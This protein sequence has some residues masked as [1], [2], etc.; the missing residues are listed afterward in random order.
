M[1]VIYDILSNACI[2]PPIAYDPFSQLVFLSRNCCLK[3]FIIHKTTRVDYLLDEVQIC[4]SHIHGTERTFDTK[5]DD[6]YVHLFPLK[7]K[8]YF[9]TVDFHLS[10]KFPNEGKCRK[11]KR[12]HVDGQPY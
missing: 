1:Q 8:R 9:R 10:G 4:I 3:I 11:S 6:I 2:S 7:G 12:C 5:L